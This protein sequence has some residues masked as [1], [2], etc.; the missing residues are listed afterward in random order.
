MAQHEGSVD[1]VIY[2]LTVTGIYFSTDE[3]DNDAVSW[4][5]FMNR[6]NEILTVFETIELGSAGVEISATYYLKSPSSLGDFDRELRA[7][8]LD[9]MF[10]VKV[11]EE[12]YNAIV[13]PVEGMRGISVTFMIIVLILGSVILILLS[14]IAI[15]ERKYEGIRWMT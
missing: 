15:R 14:S 3:V 13:G 5:V 11:D 6:H 2:N 8:G 7:K 1:P 10:D 9:D 12:T 4:S